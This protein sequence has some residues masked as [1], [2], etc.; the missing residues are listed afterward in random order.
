MM[1]KIGFLIALFFCGANL[2][3]ARQD[4]DAALSTAS[5][6]IAEHCNAKT[7][8]VIDD[9]DSH[10]Q[11][12]TLYIREQ[13]ADLIFAEDGLIQIVTREHMGK[14]EKEL[15]FQNSLKVDEKTILSVAARL[16]ANAVVFGTFGELNNA[17]NMR[18]RMLDVKTGAY[19]FRKSYEITRSA[20]TEQLLGRAAVWKKA[21]LGITAEV[22]K[23]SLE[24]VSPAIGISFDYGLTRKISAG[25]KVFASYD[26]NEKD[27]DLIVIEPVA[28]LRFYLVSPT[29]EPTSGLFLEGLGGASILLVNS[30]AT[31]VGNIGGGIGYRFSLGSFYVEP[32]FRAGYPYLFG[33][34]VNAGI[35]F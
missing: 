26:L 3:F 6:D 24:S 32:A 28:T 20:K 9:F 34:G 2:L 13:L 31:A 15:S 7:I 5:T 22:N 1:K 17:Y 4:I 8:L 29:G 33:I 21:A 10:S 27:N 30:G 16:G 23:N 19:I 14:V 12:L 25:I 35:R 18:I 11:D